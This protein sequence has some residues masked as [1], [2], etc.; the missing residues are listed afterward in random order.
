M[1][2][3]GEMLAGGIALLICTFVDLLLYFIGN[4]ILGPIVQIINT[5][6]IT[7]LLGMSDNT[8]VIYLLW[9]FLLLFEIMAIISFVAIIARRQTSGV[10]YI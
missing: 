5:Y 2:S 7:P 4:S 1:A 9:A 8:Y 10:E 6:K 3:S